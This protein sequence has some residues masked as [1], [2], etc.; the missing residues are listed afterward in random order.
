MKNRIIL[1]IDANGFFASVE[2][3]SHP[4]LRDVPMAVAGSVEARR[5]IIL[6]KNELAKKYGIKTAETVGEA[7]RKCPSLTLVP[8][9]HSH[10]KKYSK[11]LNSIYLE[12]TDLVEPFGI[13]ES[14]LDITHSMHLFGYS[15]TEFEQAKQ[16]A[17]EIR[18]RVKKE[19]SLTVSVGVS[20]NKVFAK[21]GSDYKKPDATTVITPDDCRG[22][23]YGMPVSA[24]LFVGHSAEKTLA[25]LRIHTIGQ[26]ADYDTDVLVRKLGKSGKMIQIYA[27]GEDDAPVASYFDKR[28]AKS[29][30]SGNTFP[31]DLTTSEQ[32]ESGL[33]ALADDVSSRLRQIGA[34]CSS[35]CVGVKYSDLKTVQK[36]HMLSSP[37]SSALPIFDM[38]LSLVKAMPSHKPIRSL[39]VTAVSLHY[40]DTACQLSLFDT[41]D[42]DKQKHLD[43]ALDSIRKRHGAD[44]LKHASTFHKKDDSH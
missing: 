14:W 18:Q 30:G 41:G 27:R 16:I 23:V 34:V 33:L 31:V 43:S 9:S 4:E 1:H 39:T 42:E 26:L 38:C 17:D 6:A 28:L 2:C 8:P 25:D 10:Y 22:F 7:K 35:V 12:Y 11:I 32:I 44:K 21:L 40:G 19:T 13:D 37:T 29:V 20:Y 36:Q 5:G 15:G 3:L 24:L